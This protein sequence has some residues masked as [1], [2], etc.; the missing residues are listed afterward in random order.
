GARP[1]L[2]KVNRAEAAALLDRPVDTALVDL[3]TEVAARTGGTVVLTD[4]V[5]GAVAVRDGGVWRVRQPAEQGRYAVGSGDAFLGGLLVGLD[6]GA[7]LPD[8]LRLATG[9]AV[10]NALVA[11][12][13]VLD[14]GRARRLVDT[15]RLDW[16]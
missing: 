1:S 16:D 4:G 2:T 8:A 14:P 6:A 9:C 11:G 13:G 12:Q 5:R 3:A 15:V 10:A 7:G